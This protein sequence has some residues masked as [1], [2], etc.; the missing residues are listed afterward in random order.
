[1]TDLGKS[2]LVPTVD[3][4]GSLGSIQVAGEENLFDNA[5]MLAGLRWLSAYVGTCSL[6]KYTPEHLCAAFVAPVGRNWH[7]FL[8]PWAGTRT[9]QGSRIARPDSSTDT[10]RL[11]AITENGR[12]ARP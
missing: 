2:R 10:A 6:C 12:T 4:T 8:E 11:L 1:M 3:A 9:E 7:R 5:G